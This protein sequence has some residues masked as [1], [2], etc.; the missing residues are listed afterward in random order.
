LCRAIDLLPKV[1]SKWLSSNRILSSSPPLSVSL[2]HCLS[3]SLSG[4]V[5]L[6][7]YS[8]LILL[9][10]FY[11][12]LCLF[13]F[14]FCH[15][16]K[17]HNCKETKQSHRPQYFL[18]FTMFAQQVNYSQQNKFTLMKLKKKCW[19]VIR[20]RSR[21]SSTLIF[22]CSSKVFYFQMCT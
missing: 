19:V 1:S 2:S 22:F 17:V 5:A 9:F 6:T 7:H 4:I 14:Y 20:V 21:V 11:F 18:H 13:S 16:L 8:N 10:L 12:L 15:F 3:V